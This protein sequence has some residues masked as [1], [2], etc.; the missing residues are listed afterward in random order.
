M[1]IGQEVVIIAIEKKINI[2]KK[3]RLQSVER[4]WLGQ[5]NIKSIFHN[6]L[7]DLQNNPDKF[8]NMRRLYNQRWQSYNFEAQRQN[9]HIV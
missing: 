4:F 7:P 3:L 9:G 6:F 2:S 1:K 5:E 8:L